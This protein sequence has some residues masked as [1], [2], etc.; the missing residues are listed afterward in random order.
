MYESLYVWV[1]GHTV[2]NFCNVLV[3][4]AGTIKFLFTIA[5]TKYVVAKR[6]VELLR[7]IARLKRQFLIFAEV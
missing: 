6:L 3:C 1:Y 2:A 7:S 4:N 5:I